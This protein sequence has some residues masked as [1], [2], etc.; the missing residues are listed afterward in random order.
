MA[1]SKKKT[2]EAKKLIFRFKE[3]FIPDD[4]LKI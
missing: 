2:L 1:G 3:F 4:L